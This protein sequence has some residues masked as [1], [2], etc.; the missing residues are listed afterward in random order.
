MSIYG[1]DEQTIESRKLKLYYETRPQNSTFEVIDDVEPSTP[2]VSPT[3]E[4][5]V[6]IEKPV[7][8]PT[9]SNNP[10]KPQIRET[11]HP[12]HSFQFNW[13]ACLA[14]IS[15]ITLAVGVFIVLSSIPVANLVGVGLM[16]LGGIG[17][18]VS[19]A[20]LFMQKGN[21]KR[22]AEDALASLVNA[23]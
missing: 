3:L 18:C 6:R 10:S 19:A 11:V 4:H 14:A 8:A 1:S 2:Q 21:D 17:L 9:D 15:A 13:L 7:L 20:G 16:A 12:H 22:P 5:S 23:Y